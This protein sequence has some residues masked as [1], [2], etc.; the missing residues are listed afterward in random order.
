MYLSLIGNRSGSSNR[1]TTQKEYFGLTET[2][3]Q[4][5]FIVNTHTHSHRHTHIQNTQTHTHTHIHT[6]TYT[7]T[8]THVHVLVCA[9]KRG[10]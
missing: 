2:S 9:R 4:P 3:N 7:H 8:Q 6:H 10:V 1:K 5:N